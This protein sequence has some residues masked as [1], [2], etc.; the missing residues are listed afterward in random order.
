MSRTID[1]PR[2]RQA[3]RKLREIAFSRDDLAN[4]ATAPQEMLDFLAML[5]GFKPVFLLGHGFDDPS[6]IEGVS[7]VASG[8]NLH[9]LTGSKWEA[10]RG[11]IGLP[12]WYTEVAPKTPKDEQA[13]VFICKL[14]SMAIR[15]KDIC[16]S[17][18]ISMEQEASM[19]GYPV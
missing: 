19:L 10:E 3:L 5:A 2:L 11:D 14:R 7:S 8:M 12:D 9:V 4:A 16:T 13:V 18:V 17:G 1:R 15:I 6:W